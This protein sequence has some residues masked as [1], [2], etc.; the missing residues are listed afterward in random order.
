M[1]SSEL[2]SM[3]SDPPSVKCKVDLSGISLNRTTM[4]SS[5]VV[6]NSEPPDFVM[7]D[8]IVIILCGL[9]A[10]GKVS[11]FLPLLWKDL[12]FGICI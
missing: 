1:F 12:G 3:I 8:Q 9:I 5:T 4:D 11:K 6:S 10:P 7:E 2:S